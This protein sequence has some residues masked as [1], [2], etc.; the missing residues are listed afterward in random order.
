MNT[1]DTS[2]ERGLHNEHKNFFKR[3]DTIKHKSF[4]KRENFIIN[5]KASSRERTLPP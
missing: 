4:L 5:T 2:R 3:E 1:R